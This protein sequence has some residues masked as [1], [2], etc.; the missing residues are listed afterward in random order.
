ME[1]VCAS[2]DNQWKACPMR[3]GVV[4][5]NAVVEL[6]TNLSIILHCITRSTKDYI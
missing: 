1:V 3:V 5:D 4:G 6:F 2:T